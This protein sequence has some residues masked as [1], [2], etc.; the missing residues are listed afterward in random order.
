[1]TDISVENYYYKVP[2]P[3]EKSNGYS[4][5]LVPIMRAILDQIGVCDGKH[6]Y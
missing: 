3:H 5:I 1:M 2:Y 4:E 6:Q